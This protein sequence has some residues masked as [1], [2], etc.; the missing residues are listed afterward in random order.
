MHRFR[1]LHVNAY[2]LLYLVNGY[3]VASFNLLF[4]RFEVFYHK[5]FMLYDVCVFNA[6]S[7]LSCCYNCLTCNRA[8]LGL[9]PG[10]GFVQWRR[11]SIL[12]IWA[13]KG[14]VIIS[15][16]FWAVEISSKRW[17]KGEKK[18]KKPSNLLD[19]FWSINKQIPIF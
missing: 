13:L 1:I 3:F 4:H 17:N 15:T 11:C 12:T 7:E 14:L 16:G 10:S 18:I 9:T 5:S 19:I 2:D 6:H 8:N